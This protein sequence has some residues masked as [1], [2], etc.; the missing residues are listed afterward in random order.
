[1]SD[2]VR[3]FVAYEGSHEYRR[4]VDT[5]I[6]RLSIECGVQTASPF[7]VHCPVREPFWVSKKELESLA[8]AHEVLF[9][10][11]EPTS[12]RVKKFSWRR[13]PERAGVLLLDQEQAHW[14]LSAAC[15]RMIGIE[16]PFSQ[17]PAYVMVAQSLPQDAKAFVKA[18]Q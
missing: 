14:N 11:V 15:E 16:R 7:S 10:G 3:V 5:V 8:D 18:W 4:Y 17:M 12:A 2:A 9:Q 6:N 1:M 13:R